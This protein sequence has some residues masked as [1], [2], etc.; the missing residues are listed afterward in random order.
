MTRA[1][2]RSPHGPLA[3]AAE[4]SATPLLR[5]AVAHLESRVGPL[6]PRI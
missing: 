1:D 5:A 6:A 4:R 2:A 3:V